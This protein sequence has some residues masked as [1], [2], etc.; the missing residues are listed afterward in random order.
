L[1]DVYRRCVCKGTEINTRTTNDIV[2]GVHI[3]IGETQA[4]QGLPKGKQARLFD[5]SKDQVLRICRPYLGKT[6]VVGKLR[7]LLHLRTADIAG[8]LA[9]AFP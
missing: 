5:M 6:A 8:R 4:S 2:G 1:R 3:R 9:V 7:Y